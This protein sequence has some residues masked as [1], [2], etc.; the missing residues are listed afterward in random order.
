MTG[1]NVDASAPP[2]FSPL[3]L[4]RIVGGFA[5]HLG[6]DAGGEFEQQASALVGHDVAIDWVELATITVAKCVAVQPAVIFRSDAIAPLKGRSL[7][8]L[9]AL[10][11]GFGLAIAANDALGIGLPGPLS[12]ESVIMAAM[13]VV[14]I[15][16]LKA[17]VPP[18]THFELA[19]DAGASP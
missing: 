2:P 5:K 15:V 3:G 14:M 18:R 8:V 13:D 4:R 16:L 11:V 17:M 7:A 19:P 9:K 6:D 1:W 12:K 10:A